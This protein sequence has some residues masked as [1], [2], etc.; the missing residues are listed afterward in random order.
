MFEKVTPGPQSEHMV[1]RG[2]SG[3]ATDVLSILQA[4][5]GGPLPIRI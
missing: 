3:A 2:S 5:V 1:H 4:A